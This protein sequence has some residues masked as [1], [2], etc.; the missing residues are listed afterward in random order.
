MKKASKTLKNRAVN[1]AGAYASVLLR[2]WGLWKPAAVAGPHREKGGEESRGS[3]RSDQGY[4]LC[5]ISEEINVA[6]H[7]KSYELFNN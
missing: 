7:W 3:R 6:A 5:K 2:C 1:L 4:C